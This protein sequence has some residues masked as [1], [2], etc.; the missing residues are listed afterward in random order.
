MSVDTISSENSVNRYLGGEVVPGL[1]GP[2][3]ILPGRTSRVPGRQ[4]DLVVDRRRSLLRWRHWEIVLG[5][6]AGTRCVKYHIAP[7]RG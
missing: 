1:V 2:R 6:M 3:V 7:I 5:R 4:Q